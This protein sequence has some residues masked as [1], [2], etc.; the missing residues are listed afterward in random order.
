MKWSSDDLENVEPPTPEEVLAVAERIK[1]IL[2]HHHPTLQGAVLAEL[3]S[4][5]IAGH[6]ADTKG[7]TR[8]LRKEVLNMHVEQVRKLIPINAKMIHGE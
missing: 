8:K 4:I 5:W 1:P 6:V 7:N 2:A 3:L